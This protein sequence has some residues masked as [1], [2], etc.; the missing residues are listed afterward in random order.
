[1]SG[2]LRIFCLFVTLLV[3]ILL[4][5]TAC[6]PVPVEEPTPEP[7]E[8]PAEEPAEEPVEE[9]APPEEIVE[10]TMM[11]PYD[12]E[13]LE[14]EYMLAQI[15]QFQSEHPNITVNLIFSPSDYYAVITSMAAAGDPPDIASMSYNMMA[16]FYSQYLLEIESGL[17]FSLEPFINGAVESNRFDGL[18]YGIPWQR[19]SCLPA[20]YSLVVFQQSNLPQAEIRTLLEYLTDYTRQEENAFYIHWYPTRY[21]TNEKLERPCDVETEA[22]NPATWQ[23]E[24][25]LEEVE[26]GAPYVENEFGVFVLRSLA[27]GYY[28]GESYEASLA[29]LFYN[30]EG[31]TLEPGVFMRVAYASQIAISATPTPVPGL[32]PDQYT[33]VGALFISPNTGYSYAPGNYLVECRSDPPTCLLTNANRIDVYEVDAQVSEQTVSVNP[34]RAYV[35][36]GWHFCWGLDGLIFCIGR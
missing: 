30:P 31:M 18:V 34:P 26:T 16:M 35:Q 33:P 4:L 5:T 11:M 24:T 28:E 17:G 8:E 21:D 36:R 13:G 7:V 29:P 14:A 20:Y 12:P 22:F 25:I 27:S 1:M 9:P 19:Y 32:I 2:R 15:D 10:L 3:A 6:Q 23:L